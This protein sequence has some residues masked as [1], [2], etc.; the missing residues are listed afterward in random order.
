MDQSLRHF[1]QS[2]GLLFVHEIIEMHCKCIDVMINL[3][4]CYIISHLRWPALGCRW[5]LRT[6][7]VTYEVRGIENIKKEHGSVVLMNHQ[8]AI[9]LAG[10]H[11]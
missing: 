6:L 9:D 4:K 10:D 2:H 11:N 3:Q 1:R 8:S 5:L 7:G